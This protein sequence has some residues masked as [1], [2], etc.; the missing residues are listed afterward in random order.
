MLEVEPSLLKQRH[1]LGLDR[2]DEMWE[3]VLHMS[4]APAR[5]HQR[6][7][8][9][10]LAFLIPLLERTGRGTVWPGINVFNERA[11][12]ED[13][14]IPDLTFV[15][16]G[17]DAVLAHD[18]IRGGA[19]DAVIEIRS[20]YD[21]SYEKLPFMATLGV[22]E[23]VMIDRDTKR[24]EVYELSQGSYVARA[25]EPDGSLL[26]TTLGVR[27]AMAGTPPLLVLTD[28]ADPAQRAEI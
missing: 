2:W 23:V 3:G 20:P 13:Y 28:A 1:R 25:P 27:F 7:L 10:L 6:I 22:P 17:H 24:V 26:S 18:G 9:R 8:G 11:T 14:R 5:E 12:A 21:E 19:P 4:P 16:R 15:A